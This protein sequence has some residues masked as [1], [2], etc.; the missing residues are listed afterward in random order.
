MGKDNVALSKAN[1]AITVDIN[2][3]HSFTTTA[4]RDT[5]FTSHPTELKEGLNIIVMVHYSNVLVVHG[6]IE[7]F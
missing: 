4:L 6:Q 5:Y 2:K 1:K 3:G 7:P